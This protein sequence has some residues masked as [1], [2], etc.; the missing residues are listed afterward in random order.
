MEAID[1]E[2]KQESSLIT[3]RF[4]AGIRSELIDLVKLERRKLSSLVVY[5]ISEITAVKKKVYEQ[6]NHLDDI[7]IPGYIV[8]TKRTSLSG[9]DSEYDKHPGLEIS[10]NSVKSGERLNTLILS[11]QDALTLAANLHIYLNEVNL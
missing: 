6:K 3:C 1:P 8:S 9:D 7:T 2:I 11:K 4:P 5:L 10:V